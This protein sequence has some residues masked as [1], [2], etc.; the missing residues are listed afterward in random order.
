MILGLIDILKMAGFDERKTAKLVRHQSRYDSMEELRRNDWLEVYQSYQARSVFHGIEQI[1][2]FYGLSTNRAGF[3]GVYRVLGHK[4]PNDGAD[5]PGCPSLT[6]W[7]SDCTF[8]YIL[9]RDKRF[10][11]FRDRIIIDWGRAALSW[12]QKLKNKPIVEILPPGR[13]LQPFGDFLEFSLTHAQLKDLFENEEA[14]RDWK[15]P[16]S[17]VAGVYLILAQKTGHLYIGSAYGATGFWGRWQQYAKTGDGGNVKIR[18]LIES[19]PDYPA[20]FLFSIL[21]IL[22]RSMSKDAVIQRETEYKIKLG[23]RAIGLNSN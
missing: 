19:D 12:H 1:I 22:P 9:D 18:K 5:L 10:D 2:S 4:S 17:N 16:L 8:F 23:T 21:H 7:R 11:D 15:I 14:H 20:S 13:K 3:Y 6:R